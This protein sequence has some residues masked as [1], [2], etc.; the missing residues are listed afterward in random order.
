MCSI[1]VSAQDTQGFVNKQLETYFKSRLL[2]LY[3]SCYQDYMG[4]EHLFSGRQT[5]KAYLD[6][7]LQTT[8]LDEL[9]LGT[10]SYVVLLA[11]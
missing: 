10:M 1:F 7:E 5:V 2:D 4:T 6:E 8:N 9:C 3:K 11:N